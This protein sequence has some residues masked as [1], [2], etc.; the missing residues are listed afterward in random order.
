MSI[1]PVSSPVRAA[2]PPAETSA[3]FVSG[4]VLRHVMVMT[5]TGTAGVVAIFLVDMLSLLYISWLGDA[6]LTAGVGLATILVFIA[7]SINVGLM[8]AVGAL[9]ARRLGAG[10]AQ[11]ARRVA[12]SAV[13]WS[14]VT[15]GLA[16]ALLMP[17]AGFILDLMGARGEV[18]AVALHYCL[19]VLPGNLTMAV[20]MACSG[21]LRATGDARRAMN[22]TL[23]GAGFTAMLDPILIFGLGLGVTG[24]A[25]GM[26]TSRILFAVIGLYFVQRY[27]AMLVRPR[28]RDLLDHARPVFAVAIPAILTSVASP[29]A[30]AFLAGVIARFGAEAIA[31]SAVIERITPVA[32]GGLF[33]L[34]GAVGP[35]LGQN[36]GAERFDRMR[37]TLRDAMRVTALYVMVTWALLVL[38]RDLIVT[39]FDASGDAATL[40]AFFCLVAGPIW[41]FNGLLFV[42][43]ASFNN[44]GFPFYATAFNWGR[45]TLGT[46]PPALAGA[47]IAGPYGAILGAGIGSA[48]FGCLAILT[49][50][51]TL[52]RLERVGA[53]PPEIARKGVTNRERRG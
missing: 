3:R 5:A 4:S 13:I 32:F 37:A 11:D 1:T 46:M 48:L 38:G 8:I 17:S 10:H 39:V 19:I 52:S 47:S 15:A 30:M 43:N 27:H 45:A 6:T 22:L 29:V 31:G 20:G 42:A 24:A 23:I 40:V 50:F 33:A 49:A 18:H 28:L 25:I 44:L 26:L 7:T 36:W 12:T 21:I 16:T 9:V 35:I 51:R 2:A 34:S 53:G 41:F 14:F